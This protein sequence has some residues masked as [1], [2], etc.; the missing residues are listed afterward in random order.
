MSFKSWSEETDGIPITKEQLISKFHIWFQE[1]GK[2]QVPQGDYVAIKELL[3]IAW[4]NGAHT[5][6][7]YN[8]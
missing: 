4:L 3:L 1:E 6:R 2:F 8:V 5:E 7:Y